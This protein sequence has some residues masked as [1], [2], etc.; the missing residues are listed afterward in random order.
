M[1]LDK[2][3]RFLRSAKK[4]D[5]LNFEWGDMVSDS[6]NNYDPNSTIFFLIS[7]FGVKK[8]GYV[9]TQKNN[10]DEEVNSLMASEVCYMFLRNYFSKERNCLMRCILSEKINIQSLNPNY[11]INIGWRNSERNN[12]NLR[13]EDDDR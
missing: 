8:G 1:C 13:K 6:L 11:H 9:D 2:S 4:S 3:G 5:Y 7:G 12:L 10:R